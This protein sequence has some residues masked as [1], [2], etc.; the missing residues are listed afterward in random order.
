M[1][2]PN[3]ETVQD[4]VQADRFRP[5]SAPPSAQDQ[6]PPSC[7]DR[8]AERET[9]STADVDRL[10][11]CDRMRL[12]LGGLVQPK[13]EWIGQLD[14]TYLGSRTMILGVHGPLRAELA[15]AVTES[16]LREVELR[17]ITE[18]SAAAARELR[19]YPGILTLRGPVVLDEETARILSGSTARTLTLPR[20]PLPP[21]VAATVPRWAANVRG[22]DASRISAAM[23][24]SLVAEQ[25]GDTL[26]LAADGRRPTEGA[27][28]EL[29]AWS[30]KILKL[31]PL[32]DPVCARALAGTP[33]EELWLNLSTPGHVARE[34]QGFQ[35]DRLHYALGASSR[36]DAILALLDVDVDEVVLWAGW[37]PQ[38][39][40]AVAQWSGPR[41]TVRTN[42]L[43]RFPSIGRARAHTL[44]IQ[45]IDA[46]ALTVNED[47]SQ[48]VIADL[49][50]HRGVLELVD[51]IL[52]PEATAT[53]QAVEG[54]ELRLIRSE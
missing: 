20:H 19:D 6:R 35:G 23:A 7:G 52:S 22:I 53:L 5:K 47:R 51:A 29:A 49:A 46:P 14:T 24:R 33:A 41:L 8:M 21:A 27:C 15:R 31:G 18:L 34:F 30:G 13:P 36:P 26:N 50:E 3:L 17:G 54:L 4:G 39:T 1:H 28:A 43:D 37:N 40:T 44:R 32:D 38:L 11:R 10:A 2:L 48:G 12:D 16:Q 25:E 45:A 42:S 9:L